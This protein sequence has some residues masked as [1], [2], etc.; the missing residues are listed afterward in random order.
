MSILDNIDDNI[1]HCF[2]A[3][4]PLSEIELTHEEWDDMKT[5]PRAR[6][7]QFG[8]NGLLEG[9]AMYRGIK[10]IRGASQK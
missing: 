10:I 9:K 2:T 8:E 4:L 6:L 5:D 3:G 7:L 1:S